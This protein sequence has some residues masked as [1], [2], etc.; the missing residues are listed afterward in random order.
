MSNFNIGDEVYLRDRAI[1]KPLKIKGD[2]V[3]ILSVD[4]YAVFMRN[5][6]NEGKIM[7]YD[8]RQLFSVDS[9]EETV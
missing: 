7:E 6:F 3:G 4:R 9:A 8:Y 1:G 2:I 5:G